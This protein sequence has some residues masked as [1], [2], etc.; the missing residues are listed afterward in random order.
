[1]KQVKNIVAAS[2]VTL[3]MAFAGG[4][5]VSTNVNWTDLDANA[6]GGSGQT[7]LFGFNDNTSLGFDSQYGMLAV[8]NVVA[9]ANLR[10][11][12]STGHTIGLG[13]TFWSS[14]GDGVQTSLSTSVNFTKTDS[15]DATSLNMALGFSL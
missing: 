12:W 13:Y 11:G 6:L 14:G 4:L 15:D 5:T 2:V 8:F 3:S 10:L 1:M 9:G 7:V